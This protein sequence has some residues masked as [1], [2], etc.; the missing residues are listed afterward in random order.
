MQEKELQDAQNRF[1]YQT[2]TIKDMYAKFYWVPGYYISAGGQGRGNVPGNK[3]PPTG[4]I[5]P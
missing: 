5:I 1:S 4:P 3:L 2:Y